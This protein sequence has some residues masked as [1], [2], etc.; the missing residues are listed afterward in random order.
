MARAVADPAILARTLQAEAEQEAS[1]G[2]LGR[3][4]PLADEALRW[5]HASGDDLA[6]AMAALS[7]ALAAQDPAELRERVEAAAPLLDA[8][9]CDFQLASLLAAAAY[10]A[11]CQGR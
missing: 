8:T 6:I 5:A 7:R 10:S 11:L 9:G 3:A 1:A 4:R 2:R